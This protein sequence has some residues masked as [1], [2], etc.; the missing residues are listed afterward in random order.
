MKSRASSNCW[1]KVTD[2]SRR[3]NSQE[4]DRITALVPGK[5]EVVLFC[6][7]LSL[8]R[9]SLECLA[10]IL[11]GI[12]KHAPLCCPQFLVMINSFHLP[13]FGFIF[14][15]K[16]PQSFSETKSFIRLCSNIAIN[17]FRIKGICTSTI[18]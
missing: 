2:R 8:P 15:R 14:P 18:V 7:V 1:Q 16:R 17:G 6:F 5:P 9:V 12:P 10:T 11:P 13:K 4:I 3:E